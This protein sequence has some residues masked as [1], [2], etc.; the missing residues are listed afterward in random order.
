M[1]G[2]RN[3]EEGLSAKTKGKK[4]REG[5][6]KSCDNLKCMTC[7]VAC[8]ALPPRADTTIPRYM[9]DTRREGRFN[10][11]NLTTQRVG[12]ASLRHPQDMLNSHHLLS[13][14]TQLDNSLKDQATAHLQRLEEIGR[15][16]QHGRSKHPVLCAILYKL[17]L[18]MRKL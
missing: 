12:T 5:T 10:R 2:Q 14:R 18:K 11:N 15:P 17:A 13:G 9:K 1:A 3:G 6:R 16:G 4:E 8:R 7:E